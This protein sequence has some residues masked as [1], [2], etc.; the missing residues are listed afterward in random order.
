MTL[1]RRHTVLW[2]PTPEAFAYATSQT[3]S[4][5]CSMKG[6]VPVRTTRRAGDGAT[7][8]TRDR[9]GVSYFVSISATIFGHGVFR[10]FRFLPPGTSV[11]GPATPVAA[12]LSGAWSPDNAYLATS[13][14]SSPRI[15]VR[16]WTGSAVGAAV[17]NPGT[18]PTGSGADVDWSPDGAFV[19]VAHATT[20][21]VS[22]YPWSAGA[23]GLK[24]ANPGTLPVGNGTQIR[25]HP[26]GN[27]VAVGHA[28][29]PFLSV[30]P[31][32][33]AGFGARLADPDV[34]PTLAGFV[35][36]SPDGRYLVT[37]GA[38]TVY[39][40]DTGTGAMVKQPVTQPVPASA[41]MSMEFSPD[42]G[43]F[44][45]LSQFDGLFIYR[46]ADGL[47]DMQLVSP[48]TGVSVS[49]GRAVLWSTK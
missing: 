12:A 11:L 40:F 20:P 1:A 7:F 3:L 22:V 43:Y 2:K 14:S 24:V 45:A 32:S 6:G 31:W 42:G 46:F 41:I 9:L 37:N 38:L 17:A 15:K 19:G 13:E 48:I 21:F 8:L 27:Y 16:P 18:L 33:A 23:F 39:S 5:Y 4:V 49:F 47:R 35:R 28:T 30:Y 29:S 34:L 25:W 44:I 36:W 26:S 10:G